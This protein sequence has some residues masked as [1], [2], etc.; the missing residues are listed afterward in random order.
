MSLCISILIADS[1]AS[2]PCTH[3]DHIWPTE[4]EK[5]FWLKENWHK[6]LEV[7]TFMLIQHRQLSP[8]QRDTVV[9][10]T[11]QSVKLMR[12]FHYNVQYGSQRTQM[13]LVSNRSGPWSGTQGMNEL[14]KCGKLTRDTRNAPHCIN[15]GR[16]SSTRGMNTYILVTLWATS[17]PFN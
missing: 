11:S 16:W 10:M 9:L 7:S 14:I 1:Q 8:R 2:V 4:C 15:K 13:E 6:A 3:T 5:C 12:S 17:L